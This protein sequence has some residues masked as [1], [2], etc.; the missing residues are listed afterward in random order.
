MPQGDLIMIS[1]TELMIE[2]GSSI[3]GSGGD[4]LSACDICCLLTTGVINGLQKSS[5]LIGSLCVE[6]VLYEAKI[7]YI[8]CND[9]VFCC[10]L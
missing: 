4:N 1:D 5:P 2:G 3:W 10:I 9:W 6:V 7:D 8:L